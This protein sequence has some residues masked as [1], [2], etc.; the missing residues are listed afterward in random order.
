MA[1][2]GYSYSEKAVVNEQG[3]KKDAEAVIK[4]INDPGAIDAEIAKAINPQLIFAHGRSLGGAVAI[5][6]ASIEP[7][8]FR[9]LIVENAFLSISA[10]VDQLFPFLTP[11]K[12]YVLKIGWDNDQLVPSLHLPIFFVTGDQD[13][14]VPHEHT[15]K[16]YGAATKA[17][18]KELLVVEG[19]THNDTWWVGKEDYITML[20]EFLRRCTKEYI[21]PRFD[22]WAGGS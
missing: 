17:A 5:Y 12:E 3:L 11:I 15:I 16:L 10:M 9:G 2:R 18:F 1:Y 20:R 6:M 8:L 22:D 21:P 13:E 19:G 4:F 14:L 7:D